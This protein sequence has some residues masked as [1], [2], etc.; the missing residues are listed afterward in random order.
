M[1]RQDSDIYRND[2]A[3]EREFYQ[4]I[5]RRDCSEFFRESGQMYMNMPEQEEDKKPVKKPKYKYKGW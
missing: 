5:R 4:D 1:K 2:S 3:F